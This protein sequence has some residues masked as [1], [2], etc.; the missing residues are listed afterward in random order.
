MSP[1]LCAELVEAHDCHTVILYGSRARGDFTA[2]SDWDVAGVRREGALFRI[3][4]AW[5]GTYLDAFVYSEASLLQ[6]S[7]E[8][9]KLLG[10]RL[11]FDAKHFGAALLD[12]LEAFH[13]AGPAVRPPWEIEM[14]R[15]WFL[16]TLA[17][18]RRDDIEARLRRG[19]L[20]LEALES[21][22][23]FRRQFYPGPKQGL[24][25]LAEHD[26]TLHQLFAHALEPSA[27]LQPIEALVERL[28]A[29][30]E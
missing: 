7:E 15:V 14:Q 12:R 5:G 4:K 28:V 26:P 8:L 21:S 11:L 23:R 18:L 25:W 27:G 1:D 17:R 19:W 13:R 20:L 6:P 24:A 29:L 22:F 3:A 16:K 10:G 2:E 9:L 30:A